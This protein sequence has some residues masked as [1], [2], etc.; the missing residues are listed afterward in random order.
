M[1]LVCQNLTQIEE[2]AKKIITFA[3][4]ENYKVWL[5]EGEMGVGKTTLIKAI[6]KELKVEQIVQSPTYAIVNTYFSTLVGEIFHFDFYRIKNEIE[7]MDI[8]C[9]EYFESGSYCFI[10]WPS[11]IQNLLPQKYLQINISLH[12]QNN[13]RIIQLSKYE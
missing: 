13:Q 10:E 8:G 6:C 9:E 4:E 7:A 12:S 2:V 5:F 11:C 1:E 3:A